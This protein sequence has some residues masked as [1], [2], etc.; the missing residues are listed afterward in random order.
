MPRVAGRIQ[1]SI[2]SE[3]FESTLC[4]LLL[5]KKSWALAEVATKARGRCR[6]SLYWPANGKSEGVEG[7][8][9]PGKPGVARAVNWPARLSNHFFGFSVKQRDLFQ[10]ELYGELFA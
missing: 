8:Q 9:F 4:L 7:G 10:V 5:S 6:Q 2:S 1:G 3:R